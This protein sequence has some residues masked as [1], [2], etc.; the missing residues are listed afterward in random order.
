MKF[1]DLR[2]RILL[3]KPTGETTNGM[4]ERIPAFEVYRPGLPQLFIEEFYEDPSPKWRVISSGNKVIL[5]NKAGQPF[6][7]TLSDSEY[8]YRANVTPTT[9]REYVEMQKI[10][11]ETTYSVQMRYIP[12]ITPDM[13][14]LF[15]GRKLKIESILNIGERN[16]ELQLI[17]VEVM[18]SGAK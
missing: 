14:L 16:K 13:Y 9:G 3:M 4:D 15:N 2:H 17:C 12:N 11:A 6:E 1:G 8:S 10:R 7:L 18:P 5:K